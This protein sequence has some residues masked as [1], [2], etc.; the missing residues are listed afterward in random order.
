[1]EKDWE[2]RFKLAESGT[3]PRWVLSSIDFVILLFGPWWLV[4]GV[5]IAVLIGSEK[6]K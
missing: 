6:S 4:L 2:A 5:G 3:W 1:M